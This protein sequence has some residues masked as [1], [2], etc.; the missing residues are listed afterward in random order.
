MSDRP[1]AAIRGEHEAPAGSTLLFLAVNGPDGTPHVAIASGDPVT[2]GWRVTLPSTSSLPPVLG[3]AGPVAGVAWDRDSSPVPGDPFR[4]HA[5]EQPG[6]AAPGTAIQRHYHIMPADVSAAV[7]REPDDPAT[8]ATR[9][10]LRGRIEVR[11][12]RAGDVVVKQGQPADQFYVIVSG[13]C[14]VIRDGGAGRETLARLGPGRYFGETGL[15][16]G[17]PRTASVVAA[18]DARLLAMGRAHFRAAMA[19]AAPDA[20]ALAALMQAAMA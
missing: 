1:S 12:V 5:V 18:T 16:S 10:E 2:N 9:R 13:A 11:E 17:V 6:P 7:E 4:G 15:L 14:D 3:S 19:G 20:E 8:A